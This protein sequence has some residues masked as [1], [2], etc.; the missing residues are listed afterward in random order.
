MSSRIAVTVWLLLV[1]LCVAWLVRHLAVTAD[2]TV[3]LP[4]STNPSQRLLMSQ[5]REGVATRLV[6][7]GLEGGGQAPLAQA[8][9]DLAQR[10]AASGLFGVVGNGDLARSARERELIMH[11][12]YLLSPAVSPARFTPEGLSAA[13]EES[14]ALLASPAAPFLR[15]ILPQDPTGEARLVVE[16]LVAGGGPALRDGVWFSRDGARALLVAETLAPGFDLDRQAQA[17]AAIERAF[18]EVAPQGARLLLSGS[19]VFGTT[20]RATIQSEARWLS[21][22]AAAL[23]VAI[24]LGTYRSL[25]PVALSALPVA[26]GILAGITAVACLFGAVHGITLAFGA[27][28]MG[29][30]VDY[31]SYAFIQAARG[32]RLGG[33]MSRIGPTLRLAVLTTVF[34]ASAMALSSFQGLAQLGVLTMVGVGVA[35]L[36]TRWVL[37]AVTPVDWVSRKAYALPF[38][39]ERAVALLRRG[40]PLMAVLTVAAIGVIAWRQDS[41]W[42][43][44]LAS[45][46][47]VSES[48]KALDVALRAELGAPDARFLAVTRGKDREAALEA[49]EAAET[50]LSQ[51]VERGW[52]ASYDTPARYLPSAKTQE[53]R[54]AALPDAQAL[55]RNLALATRESPFR[56][57]L[58]EPFVQAVE[59]ARSGPLLTDEALRG[60]AY[61][62][63]V[64]GLL[65]R[66]GEGWAALASLSGVTQPVALSAAL[67]AAGCA[68][69]DLKGESNSLVNGY[70]DES[71]RF[72]V[73][74]LLAIALLLAWSLESPLRAARVLVPVLMAL[75]L[76]VAILL[77]AGIRISLF[78]LVALLLVVGIGVNYALFFNRPVSETEER[79]RTL[80]SLVVCCATTLCAFGCLALSQTPV[81]RALGITVAL[82]T[83]LSLMVSA[84]LSERPAQKLS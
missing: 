69:L 2:L 14:L 10:L 64:D 60:T 7:I 83:V 52:I 13:L 15:K 24:L 32:E 8:S 34:G 48:A 43:D 30:A 54:R 55:R 78:N 63:R 21:A 65:V 61:A 23:V 29:E 3:F 56:E 37:P 84:A 53:R 20:A 12:R 39:V 46:S 6:L 77:A 26:T 1:A 18:T 81:L 67:G 73:F 25:A 22:A 4:P 35:G 19:G 11:Y 68:L 71:L 70:R 58:F 47:P 49:A 82:G 36:A 38:D 74:G 66:D 17:L 62:L 9:R 16:G 50:A 76:D 45:L 72:V 75:M 40:L 79:R 80:L 51:A 5:L 33:T 31:P 28:L 27:T 42:E 44:D 57:G 59:K 41:L